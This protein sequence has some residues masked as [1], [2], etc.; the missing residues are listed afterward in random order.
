MICE[1]P[2][3]S[4]SPSHAIAV[5]P[6]NSRLIIP[7][8]VI[9]ALAFA[10][11]PR[12]NEASTPNVA[13]AKA[14]TAA[15][16]RRRAQKPVTIEPMIAVRT[17][18]GVVHV[19]L[20]I[21]NAGDKKAE[22]SFPSGQTHDVAVLDERGREVWRWSD[23]KLFTQA[24][25]TKTLGGGDTVSYDEAWRPRAA[26]GRYTVVATL[27]SSNYPLEQRAELVLP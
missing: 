24:L 19:S 20:V 26:H 8:L 3:A 21:A 2:P 5:V 15:P 4:K 6:M 27:N 9:G 17:E 13:T 23:G 12:P 14:P 18:Q 25:Q 1:A 22:L 7:I 11:G 10:C 16:K